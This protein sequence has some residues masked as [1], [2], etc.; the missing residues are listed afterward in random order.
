[1]DLN[2]TQEVFNMIYQLRAWSHFTEGSCKIYWDPTQLQFISGVSQTHSE[3]RR[4]WLWVITIQKQE[5]VGRGEVVAPPEKCLPAIVA[6]FSRC[7]QTRCPGGP[8][9]H[10]PFLQRPFYIAMLV[11]ALHLQS[12]S[13]LTVV[14]DLAPVLL[15]FPEYR[16]GSTVCV[17]V[18]SHTSVS[19]SF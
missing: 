15:S 13:Q 7:H 14:W 11:W 12:C 10:T 18:T 5:H 16:P 2:N 17:G 1:M 4:K 9:T 6:E 8:C 3:A 19:G